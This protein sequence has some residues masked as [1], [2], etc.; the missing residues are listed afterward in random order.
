LTMSTVPE[1]TTSAASVV[2]AVDPPL[3]AGSRRLFDPQSGDAM[4][5]PVYWR[6]DLVPGV[7]I[8]GPAVIA[9]DETTTYVSATFDAAVNGQGCIVLE[10]RVGQFDPHAST[11]SA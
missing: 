10:R 3:P 5:V 4:N 7:R 1:R 6:P 9:E 11:G 8:A 2:A